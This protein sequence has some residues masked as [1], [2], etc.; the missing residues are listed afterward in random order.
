MARASVHVGISGWM[1]GGWR[2][3][4]YPRGL[5]H[6]RELEYASRRLN[7]IEINGTFY[8]LQRP[9]SFGTWYDE[10]PAGFRF[11][12]KG[13]RF[14]THMKQLNDV[15]TAVAN[16]FASGVLRLREKLGPILWQFSARRRFDAERF[17][18]FLGLLPRSTRAA[19]AIARRHDHRLKVAPWLKPGTNR[20]LRHAFE[21]RH[22]SF[23]NDEFIDVL[24]RHN[25]A[26]VFS[27]AGPEWP[28]AE[29]VTADFIYIRL[30]GAEE[31]YASGYDDS[32]LEQWAQRIRSWRAGREPRDARR[33]GT[34]RAVKTA[35]RDVYVFFDNDRKVRAPHDAMRL[36][37]MLGIDWKEQHTDE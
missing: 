22:E 36:A 32:A 17:D 9:S 4:F 7:A 8:S 1:Y 37:D 21:V 23:F 3:P 33:R 19:A 12:L 26:L 2:G 10:T 35:A 13:S 28:Y 15:H 16:Y 27:D 25:A 11:A 5:P 29:D 31:I 14:I 18:A 20:P 34:R 6:R 24:R 30:H